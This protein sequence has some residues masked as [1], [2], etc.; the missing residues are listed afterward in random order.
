LEAQVYKNALGLQK[1]PDYP[2][3]DK[4]SRRAAGVA[5]KASRQFIDRVKWELALPGVR[6]RNDALTAERLNERGVYDA[7]GQPWTAASVR[8]FMRAFLDYYLF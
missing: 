2:Y 7:Q 6:K 4:E 8:S 3:E 1:L 5:P